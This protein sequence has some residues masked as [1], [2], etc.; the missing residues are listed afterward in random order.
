MKMLAATIMVLVVQAVFLIDC[1]IRLYAQFRY[2][3][4]VER[5]V[6][7]LGIKALGELYIP[8]VHLRKFLKETAIDEPDIFEIIKED[9]EMLSVHEKVLGPELIRMRSFRYGLRGLYYY[10]RSNDFERMVITSWLVNQ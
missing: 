2:K 10:W 7:L 4:R 9:A 6:W 5:Y 8:P 3:E 1:A